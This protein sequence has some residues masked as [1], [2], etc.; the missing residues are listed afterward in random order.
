MA[1]NPAF[2]EVIVNGQRQYAGLWSALTGITVNATAGDDSVLID[3][4][5]AG[6]PVTVNLGNGNDIALVGG[7][8]ED[9]DA[10]QGPLTIH[11]GSGSDTLIIP[12]K[13]NA[14]STTYMITASSVS[15]PVP[16]AEPERCAEP[17]P[18]SPPSD[19]RCYLRH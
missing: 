12:D 3:N 18:W 9:Q 10:I 13:Y 8:A 2:V 16:Q 5:V 6:I 11:G 15:R 19:G 4:M 17:C 1:E 7:T 14:A